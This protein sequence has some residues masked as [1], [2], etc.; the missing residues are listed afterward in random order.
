MEKIWSAITAHKNSCDEP[1][2]I[3]G[4]IKEKFTVEELISESLWVAHDYAKNEKG[5]CWM[6]FGFF[7]FKSIEMGKNYNHAECDMLMY[8]SGP[9]GALKEC[10]HTYWGDNGYIFY[11]NKQNIIKALE[12]L[13][14]FY[15]M[16]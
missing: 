5:Y 4:K 9:V 3:L 7:E 13:E 1:I 16:D 12:W 11:P 8:G 2:F 15:E 10:R 6:N 14:K